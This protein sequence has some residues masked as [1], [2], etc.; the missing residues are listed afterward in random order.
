M[1]CADYKIITKLFTD[2]IKSIIVNI[3]HED[4]TGFIPQRHIGINITTF[5]DL[6]EKLNKEN[7]KGFLSLVD[8][9]KSYDNVDRDYLEECISNF[10]F[11][12][13]FVNGFIYF[14]QIQKEG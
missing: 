5:L 11:G 4:Q 7:S 1:L 9:E 10:N 2:R 14:M 8:I 6:Q 3:I 13:F 12:P